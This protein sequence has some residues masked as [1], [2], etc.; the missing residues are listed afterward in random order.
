MT[1]NNQTGIPE[2][3]STTKRTAQRVAKIAAV[4]AVIAMAL[5]LAAKSGERAS[6]TS[7]TT[8]PAAVGNLTVVVSATGNLQPTTQV[9]VGSEL[10][11]TVQEVL[12]NDNDAVQKGQLLA[13]LDTSKLE[14]Q[15]FKSEASLISAKATVTLNTATAD[16]ADRKSTRLNSSH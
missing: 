5:A 14:D 15:V 13:R 1:N 16:E 10:S 8:A 12:V 7:Y 9:D 2:T 3:V 6:R 11:G 4:V